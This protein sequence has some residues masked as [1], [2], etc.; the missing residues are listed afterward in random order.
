MD[1][2]H[3]TVTPLHWNA[4]LIAELV[5]IGG[6]A[7]RAG[8]NTHAGCFKRALRVP[9]DGVVYALKMG[10]PSGTGITHRKG[11][12]IK[13]E[14]ALMFECAMQHHRIG[15]CHYYNKYRGWALID[16]VFYAAQ[17]WMDG[18][19]QTEFIGSARRRK[20]TFRR[21]MEEVTTQLDVDAS[22]VDIYDISPDMEGR[23]RVNGHNATATADGRLRIFDWDW[24]TPAQWAKPVVSGDTIL[25]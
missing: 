9:H 12:D 3:V 5:R 19:I 17:E 16:G 11:C 22:D 8:D 23:C 21:R 6:A 4:A 15:M 7:L 1:R 13:G 2:H 18:V 10:R 14:D 25:M 24:M 20:R